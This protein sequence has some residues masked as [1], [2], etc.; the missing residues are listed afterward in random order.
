MGR[1]CVHLLGGFEARC[2]PGSSVRLSTR[3]VEALLAYLAI[4]PGERHSR[5]HLAPLFWGESADVHARQSL[6]Q[7][8]AALRTALGPASAALVVD[9][10]FVRLNAAQVDVDVAAFETLACDGTPAALERAVALYRG[11]LLPGL[12]VREPL[13]E[14]WLRAER[15]RLHELALEVLA[16]L[17]AL[18][19]QDEAVEA[20]I[21]TALRLLA[22]DPL[23]EV[24]HRALMRL[25]TRQG[26][27]AAAL[28]QYQLCVDVLQR[29]LGLEPEEATRRLYQTI[30]DERQLTGTG[31]EPVARS[32]TP[33]RRGDGLRRGRST[34][35]L[36]A[37]FIGRDEELSQLGQALSE[38]WRGH[39]TAVALVGEAGIGKTRL[40]EKLSVQASRDGGVVLW[41]RA[42][43]SA[44]MRPFSPWIEVLRG[45]VAVGGD[46]AL[47]GLSPPWRAELARLLPELG[48]RSPTGSA[49][50]GAQGRLFDAVTAFFT[51][52]ASRR[53]I[54]L[55]LEDLQWA[56]QTTLRLFSLVCRCVD[57]CP[58]LIVGTA[59][60][61]DPTAFLSQTFDDLRREDRLRTV[62]LAPLSSA[63]RVTLIRALAAPGG[64]TSVRTSVEE[65]V[66]ECSQGN[67]F[68]LIEMMRGLRE[69]RMVEPA[70]VVRLPNTIDDVLGRRLVRLSEPGQALVAVASLI[71]HESD[72]PLLQ[73]A[74]GLGVRDAAAGI[75]ELVRR[76][77]FQGTGDRFAFT[78]ERIGEAARN[79]LQ[80]PQRRLLHGQL[81]KTIENVYTGRLEPYYAELGVHYGES[82]A[83]DNAAAYLRQAA[84]QALARSAYTEAAALFE[85]AR[86]AAAHLPG[87]DHVRAGERK[88]V[89]VLLAE[90][91]V[92]TAPDERVTVEAVHAIMD[93]SLEVVARTVHRYEGTIEE[94]TRHSLMAVFGAPI[95]HEDHA[96]R[97]AEAAFDI[98]TDLAEYR[99]R[100]RQRS[101]V[102]IHAR[103][104]INTGSVAIGR[105][106]EM[107]E[108]D[109]MVTGE[110]TNLAARLQ[111]VASPNGTCVGEATYRLVRD[112]FEWRPVEARPD[113]E[114]AAALS[115]YELV[116]R[117]PVRRRFDVHAQRGLT[118]FIGRDAELHTLLARWEDAKQSRGQVVSIVG[119]AGLGKSRLIHEFKERLTHE[120]ALSLEGSCFS[121]GEVISYLPFIE[122]LKSHM[123]LEGVSTEEQ[124]RQRI[125]KQLRSLSIDRR[126]VEPYLH[127]LLAYRVDDESVS[128]LPTHVLRERTVAALKTLVLA[129]AAREPLVLIIEDVHWIDK[130]TE[131][132]IGAL[133]DTMPQVPLL[134]LLV[135]RPEYLHAW[136]GKAYHVRIALVRLP[137]ASSAEM[138][139]AILHKPY[140]S[141]V[142]V[143]RL[144]ADQSQRL[145]EELL[146]TPR[147]ARDLVELVTTHT[148]GNPLFVEELT[149][150][151]LDSGDLVRE[152]GG[153]LLRR[154]D[155]AQ[156]LPAT[157]QGVLLA[158]IDRLTNELKDVLQ[159]AA[160]VG[161][162]FSYPVLLNVLN[163][164]SGLDHVLAQ[165][166]DLDFLYVTSLT[167]HRQYSFK[168]VLTQQVVYDTLLPTLKKDLHERVGRAIEALWADRLEEVCELLAHHYAKSRDADRAVE[169]LGRSSRKAMHMN[170][171]VEAKGFFLEAIRWLDTLPATRANHRR[172]VVLVA[173]Q[174]LSFFLLYQLE[175]YYEYLIR[176]EPLAHE[177]DELSLLGTYYASMASC[178]W[179]FGDFDRAIQRNRRAIELRTI[180]GEVP[181]LLSYC[182]TMW[183]HM[184]IGDF[185]TVPAYEADVE[186]ASAK[187]T[188]VRSHVYCRGALSIASANEGRFDRGL[189]IARDLFRRAENMGDRSA[190]SYAAWL[191]AWGFIAK[192]D[193]S[194]GLEVAAQAAQLAPTPADQS[195]AQGTLAVAHCR[196]G[197]A[198]QAI[199]ILSQLVPACRAAHFV[200]AEIFTPYLAEAY[201]RAG[202]IPM[203]V[204]ALED[205]LAIIEPCRMR[206]Q[207]GMAHRLFGEI[208]ATEDRNQSI[209]H[210]E[211][212]ITLL[213][214]INAQPELALAYLAYG[215]LHTRLGHVTKAR[216]YLSRAL[217]IFEHLGTMSEPDR[218]RSEL[219]EL[220]ASDV[221]R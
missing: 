211:R 27:R 142:S 66:C 120:G 99:E 130:A 43:A 165:L 85:R 193:V 162:V 52:L 98:H 151:L 181:E 185:E 200:P 138:V 191:M 54:L 12:D 63:E 129:I 102:S 31:P 144:T 140:A 176:F 78:H 106:G 55:V 139:R 207:I 32:R 198:G 33:P 9:G 117:R 194:Q 103:L 158:R 122:V 154:L 143:P 203:A 134:L 174:W 108:T 118:R 147:V 189:E 42:S 202:D 188:D 84:I 135:Y 210:F 159:A 79:R 121:Y 81:A 40:V 221:S 112:V 69:E 169:Y 36:E 5:G 220:L 39:G 216:D 152:N 72:F 156:E 20:P 23:Q 113:T 74:A 146:G 90:V 125:A 206:L 58:V 131:E 89:T 26:R 65:Q 160:V 22:L 64:T 137:E 38:A 57:A 214:E 208:R 53:P 205:M 76:R 80:E 124:G 161:R 196:A 50:C 71:G 16:R 115:A 218:V 126:T 4:R 213:Q 24:T 6:R 192:G 155:K 132:V 136:A 201:W 199:E 149:R 114:D 127:H 186:R 100:I 217:G 92:V 48:D 51:H 88:T 75:E 67:P 7:S 19:M 35:S 44:Q 82:G 73:T 62:S 195:W 167:P 141:K 34:P 104:G 128:R 168:H 209:T 119:E 10:Q 187:S 212:S 96:L 109:Y 25:Y 123:A 116:G 179:S 56:D 111:Q 166:Q 41:G 105:I 17:L 170:A 83:W 172:R 178:E 164:R 11:D 182:V 157:V 153:Y 204:H 148:E 3:K 60:D 94:V 110:T 184:D 47:D 163:D 177:L 21:Q 70:G 91:A 175:E 101:P 18:Q 86:E 28:H 107:L 190:M 87:T 77:I 183:A 215:R 133:V 49:R 95:A 14:E 1:L 61:P 219:A 197:N 37:P 145:I 150:S 93:D 59:R 8:L 2:E 45:G 29:E 68:T 171:M 15:E 46:L 173:E 180:A 13:F 97:A 30:L